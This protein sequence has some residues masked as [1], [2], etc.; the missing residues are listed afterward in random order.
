MKVIILATLCSIP[1]IGI[2]LSFT[3]SQSKSADDALIKV[4]D[5]ISLFTLGESVYE[6]ENCASCHSLNITDEET[7]I[8]LDGLQG[9]YIISWH[10]NHLIDPSSMVPN[11]EMPSYAYL[12]ERIL[13][14]ETIQ[15]S[16]PNLTKKDWSA[17]T[18]ETESIK[19][20]LSKQG[21]LSASK[22]EI[23]A[24][25]HYL[26]NLPKSKEYQL[27]ST[28]KREKIINE[29]AI[30]DSL[31]ANS[32][33]IITNTIKAPGSPV[34]GKAVYESYCTPCHGA[35][36]EGGIG[37]NLTDDYW[38]HGGKDNNITKII[39]N[40]VPEKGMLPGKP[41]LSPI[42]V[43]QLVA[44]IKSIKGTKPSNAKLAEGAKE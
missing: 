19:K 38:I 33:S 8:S 34:Q 27:R 16:F 4:S 9:K 1:F 11:S 42:E 37:P 2:L 40:G 7:K 43:G 30:S 25:I 12:S 17:I 18:F 35:Q 15:K 31:W 26:D 13:D 10:Y 41:Q 6:R 44:Y 14:K 20:E 22:S 24:L 36:G 29:N 23:I 32:E 3:G 39:I 21:I 28:E 5:K